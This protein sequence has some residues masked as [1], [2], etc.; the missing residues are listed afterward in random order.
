MNGPVGNNPS[1][2]WRSLLEGRKVIEKGLKWKIGR[3]DKIVIQTDPWIF[4]SYPFSLAQNACY[5]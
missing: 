5:N 2:A 1:W 4:N 3:G